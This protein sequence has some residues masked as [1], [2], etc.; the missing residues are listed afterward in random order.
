[1]TN[2]HMKRCSTSLVTRE[3]QIET[4]M[5]YYY[6]PFRTAKMKDWSYPVWVRMWRN[7]NSYPLLVGG[8]VKWCSHFGRRLGSLSQTHTYHTIQPLRSYTFAQEKRKYMPI[9]RPVHRG[10]EHLYL[11]SPKTGNNENDQ[12]KVSG[13]TTCG[14]SANGILL[15]NERNY[16]YTQYGQIPK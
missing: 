11:E 13:E 14:I 15:S 10:S 2:K 6:T 5:R 12:Q 9:Q 1:M 4:T 8:N 7:Q 16:W 3:I